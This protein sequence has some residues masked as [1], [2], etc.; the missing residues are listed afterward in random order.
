MNYIIAW[1]GDIHQK[2]KRGLTPLHLAVKQYRDINSSKGIKQLLIKG[3]DRNSLDINNKRPIDYVP[4]PEPGEPINPLVID[5]RNALKD[6]WTLLGDCLMIRNT[7]KK[8]KKSPLTLICYFILM[9]FSIIMLEFSTYDILRVSGSSPWLLYSSQALFGFACFL[10]ISVW[11]S[12]PG[13]IEP[14]PS[15]NFIK[16]LDSMEASSLCPDCKII[17]TPRCR[18]CTLCNH[19]VDRYDHHCPWVNNCIGKGNFTRFY[20]FVFIQ[21]VYLISVAICSSVCKYRESLRNSSSE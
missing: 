11:F 8:Q 6:Q 4:L 12:N 3:A 10:C 20:S 2:D 18:H 14:D 19:C 9:G 15:L 13:R 16:L 1:G 21:S 17:R 5:I 7:F